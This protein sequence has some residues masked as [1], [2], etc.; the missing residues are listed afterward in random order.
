MKQISVRDM[1]MKLSRWCYHVHKC[2]RP[3]H[4]VL[5]RHPTVWLCLQGD[6]R[7]QTDVVSKYAVSGRA[8]G[9]HVGGRFWFRL[10]EG[11]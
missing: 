4:L 5:C 10:L 2:R 9:G 1:T 3:P 11:Y 8:T 7:R 6:C